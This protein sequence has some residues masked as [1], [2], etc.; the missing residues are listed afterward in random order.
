MTGETVEEETLFAYKR[1][2]S[3]VLP[4]PHWGNSAGQRCYLTKKELLMRDNL[5]PTE[6]AGGAVH[7]RV[8]LELARLDERAK[9]FFSP[10][11]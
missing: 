5:L 2:K 9:N 11:R 8:A 6:C 3:R 4:A 10:I 1:T 7:V